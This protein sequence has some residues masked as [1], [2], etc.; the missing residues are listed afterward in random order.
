MTVLLQSSSAAITVTLASQKIQL[1]QALL[2]VIGQ[3]IGTVATAVLAA[4]GANIATQRT[5]AV[6]VIFNLVSAV[7]AFIILLPLFKTLESHV[8]W[9]S[10]LEAV[11]LV[12]AF[13]TAFSI[14][15]ALF[16][17]PLLAQF[18]KILIRLLPD[19]RTTLVHALDE[20][21]LAIPAIAIQNAQHV[22]YQHLYVQLDAIKNA[23]EQ[24]TYLTKQ[25]L[26]E[27]D[28]LLNELDRYLD[29]IVLPE[30]EHDRAK[31][32]FLSRIVVYVRVFRSDLEQLMS[33]SLIQNHPQ[34]YQLALDYVAILER[35]IFEIFHNGDLS[36]CI[37]FYEELSALKDW[38]DEHRNEMMNFEQSQQL[39]AA[40]N[41]ELLAA[42]R[43]LERLIAHTKRLAKVLMG[44]QNQATIVIDD[45]R[46]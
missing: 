24:Q 28:H 33:A 45:E 4:I 7:L 26:V 1:E 12:A 46:V 15:G 3:N 44:H 34:I 41:V 25:Q 31:L 23:L 43:W 39:S 13:H 37:G 32:I 20:V 17:I 29:N 9:F 14:L 19:R 8:S 2:L 11:F 10:H 18:E 21:S 38:A 36:N 27:F 16:F 40:K 6:H 30:S 35:Y 42:Q 22:I 5:A